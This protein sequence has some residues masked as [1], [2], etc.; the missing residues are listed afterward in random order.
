MKVRQFLNLVMQNRSRGSLMSRIVN[1]EKHI[2]YPSTAEAQRH[3][4]I[5]Q[6]RG[7]IPD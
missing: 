1:P 3:L 4:Q 2:F 5:Q 6:C 7:K